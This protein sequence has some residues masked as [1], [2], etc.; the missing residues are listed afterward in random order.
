MDGGEEKT[1]T[2]EEDFNA[3]RSRCLGILA[4]QRVALNNHLQSPDS[5]YK[6]PLEINITLMV[7]SV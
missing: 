1:G 3:D 5:W 4:R 2:T 6:L 7:K